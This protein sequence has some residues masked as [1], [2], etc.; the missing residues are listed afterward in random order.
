VAAPFSFVGVG[1]AGIKSGLFASE[2]TAMYD[3]T[4]AST[5]CNRFEILTGL[6]NPAGAEQHVIE[7]FLHGKSPSGLVVHTDVGKG[8]KRAPLASTPHPRKQGA[9]TRRGAASP[10][11]GAFSSWG[12]EKQEEVGVVG[13]AALATRAA[14][15]GR[16]AA[17]ENGLQAIFLG[18]AIPRYRPGRKNRSQGNTIYSSPRWKVG[19]KSLISLGSGTCRN[20]K[21]VFDQ[22]L[23]RA[24]LAVARGE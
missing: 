17:C 10:G 13:S 16:A 8:R 3:E 22:R 15:A 23:P 11:R 21:L 4:S 14:G 5:H 12:G 7:Q 9:E 1:G 18:W 20:K 6:G 19:S 2:S 24:F